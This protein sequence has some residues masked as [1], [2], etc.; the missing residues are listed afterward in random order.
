[1]RASIVLLFFFLSL[2]LS[3]QVN[4]QLPLSESYELSNI[5]L[6]LTPYGNTD[7]LNVQ[8]KDTY[9]NEVVSFFEPVKDHPLLKRVNYAPGLE[10]EYMSFRTDAIAFSFE[11]ST[12]ELKR[13]L[14]FKTNAGQT[15]FDRELPLIND[16][17]RKSNFRTFYK[18][19]KTYYDSLVATYRSY[20]MVNEV[21]AFLKKE[22]G[23]N[24]VVQ[25]KKDYKIFLSPLAVRTDCHRTIDKSTVADFPIYSLSIFHHNKKEETDPAKQ[26]VNI[27]TLLI[28]AA[29][30]FIDPVS[31]RY[32]KEI[33]EKMDY[34][35]WSKS[36]EYTGIAVFNEYMT[37]SLYDVFVRKYFPVYADSVSTQWHYQNGERGLF[38]S[39]AFAKKTMEL[40]SAKTAQQTI[41]E[42]YPKVILWCNAF[43]KD[44][45]QPVLLSPTEPRMILDASNVPVELVFS[46]AMNEKESMDV[47]IITR[48][49]NMYQTAPMRLTKE[50]NNIS[51]SDDGKKLNFTI[52]LSPAEQSSIQMNWWGCKLPLESKK[53]IFLKVFSKVV[54]NQSIH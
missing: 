34:S 14:N 30:G 7:Q 33:N 20:Y 21:H 3:A 19:H 46:E 50:H 8:E 15:P 36:S 49:N 44:L 48:V 43:Q 18:N 42:L 37:R 53:G 31:A 40:L 47:N 11:N 25:K 26:A 10:K 16:F 52:Q 32:E 39:A 23:N 13:T 29:H 24:P 28:E 1:M 51:W 5:I 27:H 54:L 17:I 9:Y 41:L 12:N 45:S 38:A 6:S 4:I 22:C 2:R 35:K